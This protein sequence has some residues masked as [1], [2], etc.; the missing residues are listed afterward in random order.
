VTDHIATRSKL[1]VILHADVVGSTDLVRK[2]EHVAHARMQGVFRQLSGAVSSYGGVTREVR[3][4]ALVAEFERASDAVCA[5]LF[6]QNANI[7]TSRTLQDD[8]APRVRIGVAI[9][10]VIIADST[11]TGEGVILAQRLEQLAE[12]DAVCIEGSV[13]QV[14]PQRLPLDYKSLG[15][16]L[17]KGFDDPVR[18]YIASIRPGSELPPPDKSSARPESVRTRKQLLV[19][20]A[21]LCVCGVVAFFALQL[22]EAEPGQMLS[23]TTAASS[24]QK[25]AGSSDAE[26]PSIAVLAFQSLGVA[27]DDYF[28][29]GIAED[30]I[31][32]LSRVSGL[33]VIARN[34]SFAKQTSLM[35]HAE[36]KEALGVEYLLNGTVRKVGNQ[37]RINAKLITLDTEDHIWADRFDGNLDDAFGLQDAVTKAVVDA[38]KVRLSPVEQQEL[39]A[40]E[41][42]AGNAYELV[43]VGIQQ[44]HMARKTTGQSANQRARTAFEGALR[45]DPDYARAFAGLGWTYWTHATFRFGGD[46]SGGVVRMRDRAFELAEKSIA[47]SDNAFARRLLAKRALDAE[48]IFQESTAGVDFDDA[49]G[50]ARRA[51]E[52]EPNNAD[53]LAELAWILA[54]AGVVDESRGMLQK[55]RQLNPLQP[56]WYYKVAGTIEFIAGNYQRVIEELQPVHAAAHDAP[57]NLWMASAMAHLGRVDEA[58]RI[59]DLI[60]DRG[61]EVRNTRVLKRVLPLKEDAH[62]DRLLSGLIRAGMAEGPK[63]LN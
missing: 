29:R 5:A 24:D 1:A 8:I 47:L 45:I 25:A 15:E 54:L 22:M 21:L 62:M 37:L 41:T 38:L 9:G 34:S 63:P 3:G 18:P 36:L 7:E 52:L 23:D 19:A 60:T 20:A 40:R 32:D 31:T 55:A 51:V 35:T 11:I 39:S 44:L 56:D 46:A 49:V 10:E 16:Q 42:A 50:Q 2:H 4:D 26:Q 28:G 30:I 61:F 27:D 53:A 17:V 12:P 6:F 43:L 13:V 14:V 33:T 59:V 48:Q 57:V 58:K